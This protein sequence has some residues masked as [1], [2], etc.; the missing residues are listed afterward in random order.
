[1]ET[2]SVERTSQDS[3]E[4]EAQAHS[5]KA[6]SKMKATL[7]SMT[8]SVKDKDKAILSL[9]EQ[10]RKIESVK[11]TSKKGHRKPKAANATVEQDK[12]RKKNHLQDLFFR[13]VQ[14]TRV[15][16]DCP[17]AVPCSGFTFCQAK[18]KMELKQA[19]KNEENAI[20]ARHKYLLSKVAF[21]MIE[22]KKAEDKIKQQVD[23][24]QIL[25]DTFSERVRVVRDAYFDM[26]NINHKVYTAI[27]AHYEKMLTAQLN[28]FGTE[29][30]AEAVKQAMEHVRLPDFYT[31][32]TDK[33]GNKTT[34]PHPIVTQ[35]KAKYTEALKAAY[36]SLHSFL[37]VN[38]D[39]LEI[40]RISD[41]WHRLNT[42][43]DMNIGQVEFWSRE[44]GLS[45]LI[46]DGIRKVRQGIN[47]P[48]SK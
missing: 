45:M 38:P 43:K 21:G 9:R 47:P 26:T 29:D 42:F 19:D 16:A 3:Q 22:E 11:I 39:I 5:G 46:M 10:L 13:N 44:F 37:S 20:V 36:T 18:V 32:Y 41:Q 2:E 1:M 15:Y 34:V 28:I 23:A 27:R 6:V 48:N 8:K 7:V 14:Q 4:S 17:H 24:L 30:E 31:I 35:V 25:F 40:L 33:E 12:D